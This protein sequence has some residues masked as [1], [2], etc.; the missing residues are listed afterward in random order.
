MKIEVKLS[1][2]VTARV[3]KDEFPDALF[4]KHT[5]TEIQLET[6]SV[7]E[8]VKTSAAFELYMVIPNRYP[9]LLLCA[10][11]LPDN[12]LGNIKFQV[13]HPFQID[14]EVE[15]SDGITRFPMQIG[16]DHY[17]GAEIHAGAINSGLHK[18][19]GPGVVSFCG[20][21]YEKIGGFGKFYEMVS[22]TVMRILAKQEIPN[23]QHVLKEFLLGHSIGDYIKKFSIP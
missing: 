2:H 11:F 6:Q 16:I 1:K 21:A 4:Q 22:E 19:L 10:E 13:H 8:Q 15:Y 5:F 20:G 23:D 7:S 18:E 3:W 17:F 9:D 14:S 12:S